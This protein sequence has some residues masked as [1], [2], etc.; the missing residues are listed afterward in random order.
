[1]N[2]K[3]KKLGK[4]SSIFEFSISKLGYMDI[5]MKICGKMKWKSFLTISLFNI[6]YLA[7]EDGKKVNVKNEDEDE[8]ICKNEF[9]FWILHITIRLCDHF[10]GNLR[11]KKNWHFF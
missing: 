3:M 7:D 6:D 9:D 5:F 1:M 8:K 2:T 11:R 4:I 10:H